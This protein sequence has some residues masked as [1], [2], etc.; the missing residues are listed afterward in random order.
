M[1]KKEEVKAP[2]KEEVV[3]VKK[4]SAKASKVSV[5]PSKPEPV[6]VSA[7]PKS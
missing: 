1:S 2:R 5:K 7:R 3:V 4:D 6:V